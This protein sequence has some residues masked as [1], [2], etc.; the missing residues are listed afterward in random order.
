MPRMDEKE[1]K[2]YNKE[3]YQK[4]IDKY[5]EYKKKNK[6]K[7]SAYT[8]EKWAKNKDNK[9]FRD[10]EKARCLAWYHAN[11]EKIREKK[12]ARD[13]EWRSRNKGI[14]NFHTNKRYTARKQRLPK[15]ITEEN[16]LQI[17]A[18]YM[19]ASSLTKATGIE[20]HVDHIIPLQGKTVSGLHVPEN[21]QV[22]E[23]SLNNRKRNKFDV[24]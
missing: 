8:K 23:G 14:I 5:K 17:K 21:L 6:E 7:I 2:A 18:M 10:K 11:F 24:E 9:E 15:W 3:Y 12:Y 4:N 13:K 20:W 19:L 16:K 22:I 1:R